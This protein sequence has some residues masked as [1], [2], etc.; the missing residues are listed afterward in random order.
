[1]RLPLSLLAACLA[2]APLIA[3][4]NA[5][6]MA[7]DHYTRSHDYDLVHQRIEVSNFDWDSTSFDGQVT[8]TLVARR[9]RLDSVILDA[10]A[11]L[12]LKTV[13][14]A[15]GGA[16]RTSRHGDT[17]VVFLPKPIGYGDTARFTITYH[18]VVENGRGLTYINPEGRPHRP[19]QIWSQGEDHDNHYWFPTYDFPNDKMTW[20]VVATVPKG[21]NAVSNG[22]LV[23]D[24]IARDGSRT[25]DWR[26]DKPSATYLVSIVVAPLVKVHDVWRNVPV[27]Y[28]VYPEDSA[29]A[30][31]F[32]KITP[33][34]IDTYSRLTGIDYPWAKYAQTTVADFFGGMENVS[35]TTLVDWLPGP[36]NYQDRP[37]YSWILIPHE[38]SHQWFGDY[39]T[40]ENWAN[41]WLNEG[42]AEFMP[43][44]Y[45]ARK[46][47]ARAEEDY[48]QDEYDQFMQ[49]DQH[50]RQ[51]VLDAT[52]ENLDWFWEQWI[53]QAG[54]PEFVVSAKYDSSTSTAALVVQQVQKDSSKADST[55]LRSTT[56]TVFRMPVTVRVGTAGDDVTARAQLSQREDTILVHGVTS[57]PTMVI[58]DDGN[59]ILKRL[60]FDQPTAWLATQLQRDPNLWN[61]HWIIAQLAHRTADT[62][63]AAAVAKA[64][65][66]A[67]YFLVRVAA[68][69]ALPHFPAATALPALQTAMTDTSAQV[70]AAAVEALGNLGGAPVAALARQ[71]WT[72]DSSDAVRAAAVMAMALTDTAGRRAI[73]LQAL[74]TPSYRDVIQIAA[75]RAIAQT[76][77][78][79][80]IDSVDAR[81]SDHFALHVLAAL[82]GRGNAHALDLLVKRLDDE[83]PYVR[84]WAL[85][86]FRFSLPRAIGQPKLQAISAG[87][88][89]PDTKRAVADLL[90]QW[91]KGG[92]Q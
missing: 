11:K 37:W 32:F 9:A 45:W 79:T 87:L 31:P 70:R 8:T 35:A 21:M 22:R 18:G 29:L 10:G 55:G 3:Q 14:V 60:T 68:L 85:E 66:S 15:R 33:D 23:S 90:Q 25:L 81:A 41:M 88:K 12:Q 84:R 7:N 71:A 51:A 72:R 69:G 39:V 43:G 30:R 42:F 40:T 16:L 75:Y 50:L 67:D 86:A 63:A 49:I 78:T 59:A 65:T 89:F 62:A 13:T 5:E 61:R 52:G 76:A 91:Q 36:R 77:D 82:A 34:M 2:A 38:L 28:Y 44:Q 26:Q 54:Y 17:L 74:G 19:R 57:A 47:G 92:E 83:R 27:D 20:E 24:L 6:L 64:A 4:S 80:L 48:Y 1:M 46:L 73:I 56:P 53:Y 58:F